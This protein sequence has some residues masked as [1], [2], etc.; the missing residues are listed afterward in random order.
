[1]YNF[2][3]FLD[4]VGRYQLLEYRVLNKKEGGWGVCTCRSRLASG[5]RNDSAGLG[6]RNIK[7]KAR[8]LNVNGLWCKNCA[9]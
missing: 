6:T 4:Q 7:V 8:S 9:S 5:K 2:C 1:M 3:G